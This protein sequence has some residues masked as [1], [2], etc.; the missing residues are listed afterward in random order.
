MSLEPGSPDELDS[1]VA[2]LGL[3]GTDDVPEVPVGGESAMA[4]ERTAV[5]HVLPGLEVAT[6]LL[7]DFRDFLDAAKIDLTASSVTDLLAAYLSS[8]LLLF[9][10]P[11][12]TGK[13]TVARALLH[14]F[15]EPDAGEV[16]EGRRQLIGP[17]DVA[18]YLSPISG[19]YV[20]TPELAALL[21]IGAPGAGSAPGLL[22]EEINLSPVEGYLAPFV[23][24]LSGVTN[25]TVAWS[26]H[27]GDPS[28]STSVPR[29][30]EFKPYPR[31]LGSINVDSTALAP[32]PKVAARACVVLL[33][34]PEELDLSETLK[35]LTAEVAALDARA[36]A[37]ARV[38]GNPLEIF[39]VPEVNR[40]ALVQHL[41]AVIDELRGV[42]QPE[43][44]TSANPV[45]RRQAGQMLLYAAWFVLIAS[46]HEALGG[47]LEADASRLGVENAVLHYVLPTL[48]GTEFGFVL[49]R[50]TK[51][52]S[53]AD[54]GSGPDRLGALLKA[55]IDRLGS[56]GG[57]SLLAGRVLDFWDRL[58]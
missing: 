49:D 21:R 45:T 27:S 51:S 57:D 56:V 40:D 31:L 52:T 10:G 19:A 15:T 37:W 48:P 1:A 20:R 34:P 44:A 46:A 42:G 58:S 8:Q 4:N 22:V 17:E 43:E 3:S 9:A 6:E 28:S 32:S 18:G 33:E 55:R 38:V 24:G 50:L 7:K 13:S 5:A 35:G 26:L 36:G 23:H 53:L 39:D 29:R 16:I 25:G 12:G 14:F 41:T 30:I 47:S 2:S 54:G 11:S